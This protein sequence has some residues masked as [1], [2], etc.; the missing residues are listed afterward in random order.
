MLLEFSCD[1]DLVAVLVDLGVYKLMLVS[2]FCGGVFILSLL[3][4]YG[5]FLRSLL[6]GELLSFIM[7]H[8]SSY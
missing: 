7:L 3:V 4:A 5:V 6:G 1:V 8:T 2:C